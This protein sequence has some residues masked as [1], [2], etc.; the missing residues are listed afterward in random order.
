[1]IGKDVPALAAMPAAVCRRSCRR[2]SSSPAAAR[3]AIPRL[4]HADEVRVR[5][6]RACPLPGTRSG[7]WTKRGTSASTASAGGLSAITFGPVLESASRAT[8][9]SRSI[10]VPAQRAH[11]VEPGA[12]QRQ[13][14][15]D[16]QRGQRSPAP[17]AA[18]PV[19]VSGTVSRSSFAAT[20]S[21]APSRCSSAAR[22]VAGVCGPAVARH[23]AAGFEFCG[24]SPTRSA[25]VQ[26]DESTA[27][28]DSLRPGSPSRPH[29]RAPRRPG[30]G[31]ARRGSRAAAPASGPRAR[32]I[33]ARCA[34]CAGRR[35]A[36]ATCSPASRTV[37]ASRIVS[38]ARGRIVA[39]GHLARV[40][41]RQARG[42]VERQRAHL[43]EREPAHAPA[44]PVGEART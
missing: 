42:L 40:A 25:H 9:A 36:R 18:C 2:T 5:L 44:R 22:Q 37:S 1:M 7:L 19:C 32:G 13:Q 11:L 39:A 21:T 35:C 24:R 4:M 34:A 10:G 15:D 27:R 26:N 41:L 8:P 33:R 16:A 6:A 20:A 28:R 31:R 43:A 12:R 3:T 23:A 14:A 38:R 30:S 17:C 29:G